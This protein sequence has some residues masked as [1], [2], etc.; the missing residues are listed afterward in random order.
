MIRVVVSGA[1]GR[2]GRGISEAVAADPGMELVGLHDPVH[3]GEKV[4]LGGAEY[5]VSGDLADLLS[6]VDADITVDFTRPDTVEDNVRVSLA[7][8]V[9][10]VVGTTG[11]SEEEWEAIHESDA[12]DGAGL[13]I[14]PN[15]TTGA[16]LMMKFAEM[17]AEFFPDAEVIEFHHNGKRDAPSGTAVRTAR[18]IAA[19]RES[20]SE[21]PGSETEL[22]GFEGAR[23]SL[24]D[25]VP[26]H[27]VRS[28]GYVAHQEVVLGS[29]GQTLTIRHDS[30]D[31]AS[32][33]PGVLLAIRHMGPEGEHAGRF[34][35]GL[36][37][38]MGL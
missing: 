22:T 37:H 32:Y 28:N 29:P 18:M 11:V 17:A 14:A 8:G 10:P 19:A 33:A 4:E 2:M 9:T 16:V 13:F 1:C 27:A 34:I 35:V 12:T 5:E 31:R 25:G 30:I 26:V 3:V 24:V 7:A 20:A 6:E 15:F 36:E 21:A 38:L 23:G